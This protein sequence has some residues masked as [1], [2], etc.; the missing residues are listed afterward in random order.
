MLYDTKI[1]P[2]IEKNIIEAFKMLYSH[3]VYHGDDRAANVLVRE[4]VLI[5][6]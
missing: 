2:R 5:D 1:T 3:V 4:V 6:F